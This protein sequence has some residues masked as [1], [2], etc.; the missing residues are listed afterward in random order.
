MQNNTFNVDD[1]DNKAYA[2]LITGWYKCN[3]AA[4]LSF[5]FP[6]V[7]GFALG[8]KMAKRSWRLGASAPRAI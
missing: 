2:M 6:F 7:S 3:R 4:Y 5:P 8:N 1:Y